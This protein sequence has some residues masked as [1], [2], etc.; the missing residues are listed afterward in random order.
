MAWTRLFGMF[1]ILFFF[2]TTIVSAQDISMGT[3]APTQVRISYAHDASTTATVTWR[4]STNSPGSELQYGEYTL[5]HTVSGT[6]WTYSGSSGTIHSAEAT[7]LQPGKVYKYRVGSADFGWSA[8]STFM[9]APTTPTNFTFTVSG[10]SRT[11]YAEW[12]TVAQ[13]MDAEG[14][15]F[16]LFAADAVTSGGSQSDWDSFFYAL[17]P[18][19]KRAAFMPSIGNHELLNDAS[20]TKYLSQ[21]V[22]PSQPGGERYYSFRWGN[23]IFIILDTT[24][25]YS[26]G[27]AQYNFLDN[28]LSIASADHS[29]LWKFVVIHNPPYCSGSSHG[30]DINVRNAF[31]P[32]FDK[33]HVDVAFSGH[34]HLY[35]RSYPVNYTRNS[36]VDESNGTYYYVTAGAGAPLNSVPGSNWWT[37][38]TGSYYH[39]VRVDISKDGRAT[40]TTKNDHGNTIETVQITK[41]LPELSVTRIYESQN[42]KTAV[43]IANNGRSAAENFEVELTSE[44]GAYEIKTVPRLGVGQKTTLEFDAKGNLTATIDVNSEIMELDETNNV[45]TAQLVQSQTGIP[46]YDNI[47]LALVM[48]MLLF[49]AFFAVNR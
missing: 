32:L 13:S 20:A 36:V 2:S 34:D 29:I 28:T 10:D 46:E 22:L 17:E 26:Q 39:Y 7:G 3:D 16:S 6:K 31:G 19:S 47:A 27:S 15:Q 41:Q 38:K 44:E 30:S 24:G 49:A 40:L 18:L 14:A 48:V 11:N 45:F 21:Y 42:G 35:E 33:Y 23:A 9:T 1:V 43:E 5:D 37:A 12:G 8:E 4:T 25:S